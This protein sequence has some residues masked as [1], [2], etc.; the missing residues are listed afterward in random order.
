MS[1]FY[2][3]I[4]R[5]QKKLLTLQ[6]K[7]KQRVSDVNHIC[8]EHMNSIVHNYSSYVLSKDEKIALS[9]GLENNIPTK[10]SRIIINTEFEQFYRRFLHHTSHIPEEDLTYIK[11]YPT[12]AKSTQRSEFLINIEKSRKHYQRIVK[13]S[14]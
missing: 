4:Y 9:Y 6:T 11:T 3:P 8:D 10:T 7:Q 14:S 13:L 1:T 2:A 12:P 5:H